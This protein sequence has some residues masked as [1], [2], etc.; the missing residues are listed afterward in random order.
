VGAS[1]NHDLPKSV[2][3]QNSAQMAQPKSILYLRGQNLCR[4]GI[5]HDLY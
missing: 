5:L 3:Y 4:L 2:P 1:Q